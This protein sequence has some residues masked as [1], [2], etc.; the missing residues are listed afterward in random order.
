MPEVVI[1]GAGV[2][3]ASIAAH[4]AEHGVRDVLLVE[5]ASQLGAGSTARATGGFRAQFA[6]E[7]NVR[8]SLLSREELRAHPELGYRPC[9][10]LFLARAEETLR[11]LREAQRVQH[12]CGLHEARM[13]DARE[14]KELN[15][16]IDDPLII[17]GAFC[18]TDG[19][20]AP[21]SILREYSRELRIQFDTAVLG[22]RTNGD[23]V[24]AL[25]T[26]RGEIE[27]D[28]FVNAAGAW[29]RAFG[30]VPVE[31]LE[32][33]V[34]PTIPTS[35]LPDDMPMTIWAEDGFHLRVR[36][37]RVLL[38]SPERDVITPAHERVPVLRDVAVDRDAAWSGFY[39][40]SPD[41]HAIVGRSMPY[42]NLFLA[43]GS[44]GHGVMHSPAI[45]RVVAEL[46]AGAET[47]I[48]VTALRA[49]R[50]AEG[51]PIEAPSLL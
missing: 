14:A 37:G 19:F 44:S 18:P 20:L 1:I 12:A 3:G 17:G 2:I 33:H 16:A 35:V 9:G 21:M 47:S 24:L 28:V 36:D 38:L 41:H 45:G 5:R 23:R 25:Q 30:D 48:D 6:T 40:M 31:P 22:L 42:T 10:Y 39:E 7:V 13:I 32:R 4:L 15:P 50:F 11:V 26:S 43:N 29:A 27:G 46:I 8:M 34:M 49:S 51:K